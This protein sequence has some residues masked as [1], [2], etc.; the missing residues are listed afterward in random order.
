MAENSATKASMP[1]RSPAVNELAVPTVWNAKFMFGTAPPGAPKLLVLSSACR[2]ALAVLETPVELSRL[3]GT[4]PRLK[5][6]A[7][8]WLDTAAA[9]ASAMNR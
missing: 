8:A 7:T 2:S 4:A 9:T 6:A 5:V 1:E 3:V